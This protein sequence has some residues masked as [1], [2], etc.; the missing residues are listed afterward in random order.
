MGK[1]KRK[2]QTITD[3]K[4]FDVE[5]IARIKG[6]GAFYK[7]QVYSELTKQWKDT[8]SPYFY[9]KDKAKIWLERNM[10]TRDQHE[11]TKK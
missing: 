3:T 9:S 7:V 5:K 2:D 8:N 4:V 11:P 10:N 6:I 1:R